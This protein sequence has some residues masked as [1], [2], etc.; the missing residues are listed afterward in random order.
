MWLCKDLQLKL[1]EKRDTYRK[2]KQG[3]KSW[4]E[5]SAAV[6]MCRDR[7]RKDKVQM[8]LNLA[9]YV[10]DNTKGFYRYKGRRRQAKESVPPLMKGN[11]ELASSDIEKAEVLSECFASVFM[12]GQGLPRPRASR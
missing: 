4:E 11:R 6:R 5:Y 2:W 7:I 8:E 3:C 12:S 9:R 1:R 10:K